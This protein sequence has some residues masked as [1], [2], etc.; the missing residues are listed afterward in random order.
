[1]T[2]AK[3]EK[4]EKQSSETPPDQVLAVGKTAI[5][6][7]QEAIARAQEAIEKIQ[8]EGVKILESLVKEGG[9]MF[10]ETQKVAGGKVEE[11]KGRVE[12]AR[13]KASETFDNLEHIFEERVSRALNRLGIPTRDDFQAIAKRLDQLNGNVQTLIKSRSQAGIPEKDD[14]KEISGLGPVLEGKLNSQ[15]IISFR[16]IAQL[17]PEE[18]DQIEELLHSAGR[19]QRENWIAQAKE[20]HF[21]KYGERL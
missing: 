14:L 2:N 21:K 3:E 11:M 13:G 8:Q 12:E 15:G 17:R 18:I 10:E 1:M 19:I 16:Q 9:K 20:L 4:S 6:T 7:A 5:E